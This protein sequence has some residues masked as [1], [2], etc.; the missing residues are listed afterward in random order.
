MLSSKEI[1]RMFAGGVSQPEFINFKP[2]SRVTKN[3]AIQSRE[4]ST[5]KS[6]QNQTLTMIA[7]QEGSPSFEIIDSLVSQLQG[8]KVIPMLSGIGVEMGSGLG[9]LSASLINQEKENSIKGIL[10]LEASLPF[11]E[12]GI[13]KAARLVLGD[14]AF[15]I[16]PCYGSFDSIAI[17]SNSID[18]VIQIE[19]LHHAE[20]L[21]PPL[22]EGYRILKSGGHFVSIDRSWP[23]QVTRSVLTE[24]L[25]HEYSKEWLD[26]KGFPSD[27]P[28]SRRDNGEHEYLD[29][30]WENSFKQA[31]FKNIAIRHLHPKISIK[32]L[33]K[34]IVCFFKLNRLCKIKVPS[35]TGIFRGFI[36][37]NLRLNIFWKKAIMVVEH[38]RPLTVS[39][40]KK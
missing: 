25:N 11:V 6:F 26:L 12:E 16:M 35:R 8:A 15:K 21:L 29:L 34:R 37:S 38:P 19:S 14:N 4:I 9:L 1:E 17:E 7:E 36:Q 5:K 2:I 24:L 22:V 33:I 20:N 40:W 39:V 30:D 28:F 32:Q 10:A 18:F 31:G 13:R 23:N 3:R 27:L